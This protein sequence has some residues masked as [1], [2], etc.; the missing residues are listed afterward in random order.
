MK[1]ME[2]DF[3]RLKL[4]VCLAAEEWYKWRVK[5]GVPFTKS[6]AE[7]LEKLEAQAKRF[8]DFKIAS[9]QREIEKAR[10]ASPDG[11]TSWDR[12]EEYR[13]KHDHLPRQ[14]GKPQP[15]CAAC[16]AHL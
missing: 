7:A 4:D 13:L 12:V 5:Q 11:K 10:A 16:E 15:G 3:E 8:V 2:T 9:I 1:K 6:E 14:D